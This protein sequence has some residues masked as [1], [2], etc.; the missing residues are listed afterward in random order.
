MAFKF[1]EAKISSNMWQNLKA[2]ILKLNPDA[3]T[4]THY[5]CQYCCPKLN[6]DQM[7]C[8]CVLNAL[9]LE[10]VPD[11]LKSLDPLSKQ[12]MQRAKAV[13]RLGAYTGRVPSHNSVFLMM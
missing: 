11:E 5:V 8:R 4:Q 7:P 9:E 6:A 3:P 13:F 2:R 12:L 1:H 10:P